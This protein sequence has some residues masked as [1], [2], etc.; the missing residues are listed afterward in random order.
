MNIKKYNE[1]ATLFLFLVYISV[2]I[3]WNYYPIDIIH[4]IT[5]IILGLSLIIIFISTRIIFNKKKE[6]FTRIG[7]SL[8][9]L[10]TIFPPLFSLA[11]WMG[12]IINSI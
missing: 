4:L 2:I 6:I 1:I 10:C 11:T 5:Y 12:Y 9:L 7:F 8:V 3:N